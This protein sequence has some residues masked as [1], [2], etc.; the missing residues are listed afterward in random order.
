[1]IRRCKCL[2]IIVGIMRLWCWAFIM[3]SP[4]L[5]HK[6]SQDS[7]IGSELSQ[8]CEL[9]DVSGTLLQDHAERSRAVGYGWSQITPSYLTNIRWHAASGRR[10]HQKTD[11]G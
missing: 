7:W 11:N 4:A 10:G 8:C 6:H 3:N 2:Q 1:M 9:E 5:L